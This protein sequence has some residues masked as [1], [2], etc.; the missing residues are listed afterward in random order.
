MPDL[1][2]HLAPQVLHVGLRERE[3]LLA[4]R[5]RLEELAR[6]DAAVVAVL[7]L[8]GT[9]Y[10]AQQAARDSGTAGGWLTGSV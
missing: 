6:E 5:Q 10:R 7:L 9:L 4:S 1:P 3:A 8:W 2:D